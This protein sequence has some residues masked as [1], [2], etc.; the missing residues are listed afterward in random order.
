[1]VTGVEA[2]VYSPACL[3]SDLFS[4]FNASP[5]SHMLIYSSFT[6]ESM[7]GIVC[8]LDVMGNHPAAHGN[9]NDSKSG[10]HLKKGTFLAFYVALTDNKL[11]AFQG[12]T[13]KR[14]ARAP[15]VSPTHTAA[16]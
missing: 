15:E 11:R 16:C 14:T 7:Q 13:G 3:F 4:P 9:D 12:A 2:K 8:S 6:L 5:G 10:R 1:M